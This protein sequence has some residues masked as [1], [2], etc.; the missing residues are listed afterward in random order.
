MRWLTKMRQ[1]H[2]Q[3]NIWWVFIFNR[4]WIIA[5]ILWTYAK[6][7][8]W[9]DLF[10]VGHFPVVTSSSLYFPPTAPLLPFHA[11]FSSSFFHWLVWAQGLWANFNISQGKTQLGQKIWGL[12][13]HIP[14]PESKYQLIFNYHLLSL[15][16]LLLF[17]WHGLTIAD[18]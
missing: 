14:Y 6:C 11:M 1:K 3:T 12:P 4:F 16:F 18:R 8:K 10:A 2:W 15:S 9:K 5:I 13:N 17:S 7:A